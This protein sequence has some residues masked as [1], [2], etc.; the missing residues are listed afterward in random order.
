V[1][2]D[3]SWILNKGKWRKPGGGIAEWTKALVNSTKLQLILSTWNANTCNMHPFTTFITTNHELAVIRLS[4]KAPKSIRIIFWNR[5]LSTWNGWLWRGLQC[6]P[7]LPKAAS[8]SHVKTTE[9]CKERR[10]KQMSKYTTCTT[11]K[12]TCFYMSA[13]VTTKILFSMRWTYFQWVPALECCHNTPYLHVVL[14]Y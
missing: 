8:P 14:K 12:T 5:F 3:K 10:K 11:G 9:D 7:I 1:E 2:L 4:T 6:R 13:W